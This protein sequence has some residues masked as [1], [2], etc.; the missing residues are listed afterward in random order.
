LVA[1]AETPICS[2][3][4]QAIGRRLG[5]IVHA[6][7]HLEA[8]DPRGV[9][10]ALVVVLQSEDL[11]VVH[12]LAFEDAAR[13]ME[14]VGQHVE[15]CVAPRDE[16]AIVPDEAVAI[17][18]RDHGHWSLLTPSDGRPVRRQHGQLTCRL[19]LYIPKDA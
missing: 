5:Q 4:R 13:I 18:E 12:A 2:A 11:A 3:P 19:E 9:E 10:E 6:G 8:E 1:C 16:A 17:V 15:F 14:P 7:R